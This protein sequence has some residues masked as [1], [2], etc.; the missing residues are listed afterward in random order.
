VRITVGTHANSLQGAN[1]AAVY[2]V[3]QAI[4]VLSLRINL[5]LYMNL[6]RPEFRAEQNHVKRVINSDEWQEAFRSGQNYAIDRRTF[7]RALSWYRKGLVGENPV[8]QLL[9]YWAVLESI[10]SQF[11]QRNT[12]TEGGVI[13]QICNCF[14]QLWQDVSHW[15]VIT[16]DAA[17]VNR[18]YVLRNEIA[19]GAI[20]VDIEKIKEILKV[21]P[22]YQRLARQFLLDWEVHGVSREQE[23]R[24]ENLPET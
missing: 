22:K 6:F 10:S 5:P 4:D 23:H 11:S 24:I 20:R 13:N 12:R 7:S 16:N 2:F 19:H 21:L 3:G 18:F 9:A 17:A 1:D 14:D 15:K 8:D